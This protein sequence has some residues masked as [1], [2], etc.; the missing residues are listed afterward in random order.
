MAI[1]T[2]CLGFLIPEVVN[3]P[4]LIQHNLR[5][6]C[7]LEAKIIGMRVDNGHGTSNSSVERH[8]PTLKSHLGRRFNGL[9]LQLDLVR[10]PMH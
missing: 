9:C 10:M 6:L 2:L 5:A 8:R 3:Y 4:M 1:T 7:F